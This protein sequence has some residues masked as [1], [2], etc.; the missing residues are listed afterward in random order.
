MQTPSS[1]VIVINW[2]FKMYHLVLY[3]IYLLVIENELPYY[4]YSCPAFIGDMIEEADLRPAMLDSK[5][6]KDCSHRK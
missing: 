4:I 2:S 1:L 6:Y 3:V 5:Q